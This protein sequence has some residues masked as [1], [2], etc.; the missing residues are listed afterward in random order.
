MTPS[1]VVQPPRVGPRAPSPALIGSA[2]PPI[3]MLKP[4]RVLTMI[5]SGQGQSRPLVLPNAEIRH[6]E[7]NA[8]TRLL[9]SSVPSP[10][11]RNP[12]QSTC[13]HQSAKETERGRKDGQ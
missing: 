11:A 3:G 4:L 2:C 12:S 6:R 7:I 13:R 10:S 5:P 8:C 9:A 1:G